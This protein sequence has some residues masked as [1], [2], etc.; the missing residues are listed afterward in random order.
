MSLAINL[1]TRGRPEIMVDTVRRTAA[2]IALE[3]TRLMISVDADDEATIKAIDALSLDVGRGRIEAVIE[4][5][6]DSLGAK[7]NRILRWPA[8]VY[9]TMADYTPHVTPGFDRRI[10][11]AAN[12]FPDGIGVVLN[13][14]ANRSFSGLVAPTK[15]LTDRLGYLFPPHFP[16]WFVDHWLEDIARLIDRY[17]FADVHLGLIE[18]PET[19]ERRE[20]HFWA[21]F[22]DSLRLVRRRQAFDIIEQ[23]DEPEWR[24]LALYRNYPLVEYESQWVNDYVRSQEWKEPSEPG[25]ERYDRLKARALEMMRQEWPVLKDDMARQ[26][27]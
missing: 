10:L 25:G 16:Y 7:Y 15:A 17:V 14:K 24:K 12:H 20:V 27:R 4:P 3:A 23:L 19:Q 18:K 26:V 2:N 11:E 6:E 1:I 5:R 21:T 13:H 8:S 22:F 9:M